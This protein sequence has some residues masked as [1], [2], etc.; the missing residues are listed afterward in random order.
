MVAFVCGAWLQSRFGLP[1]LLGLALCL[2]P[3]RWV[4]LALPPSL[5]VLVLAQA[6]H[7]ITFAAAHLAGV[8]LVQEVV[9]AA[10]RRNAQALYSGLTFGLGI[11]VGTAAAGPLYAAVGGGGS[12]L[13]AAGF[14][15]LVAA[16]WVLGSRRIKK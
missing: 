15:V 10:A 3:L 16:A 6:G 5:P 12:F 9:P 2:T 7:A 1:R 14:S 13:V 4:L 11:V 8:Q